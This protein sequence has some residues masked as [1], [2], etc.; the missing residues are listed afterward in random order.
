MIPNVVL[1]RQVLEPKSSR[2]GV[3]QYSGSRLTWVGV[4]VN[5]GRM[6]SAQNSVATRWPQAVGQKSDISESEVAAK[7]AEWNAC[8]AKCPVNLQLSLQWSAK[9]CDQSVLG[10][11]D[12]GELRSGGFPGKCEKLEKDLRGASKASNTL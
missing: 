12:L 6:S 1:R 8:L 4:A 10:P 2:S 7:K 9:T 11:P 3:P 5:L